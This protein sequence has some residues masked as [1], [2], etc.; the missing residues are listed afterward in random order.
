[1]FLRAPRFPGLIGAVTIKSSE[2]HRASQMPDHGS[3]FSHVL[4]AKVIRPQSERISFSPPGGLRGPS[5]LGAC[6][7]TRSSG[8][9]FE[10]G[11][12][13]DRR[14]EREGGRSGVGYEGGH[15]V[16]RETLKPVAVDSSTHMGGQDVAELVAL[17]SASKQPATHPLH[18]S[19]AAPP[20]FGLPWKGHEHMLT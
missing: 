20:I 18:G 5:P 16:N 11:G 4:Q 10:V 9:Q 3:T 7:G 12:L 2:W 6:K 1:M 19:I 8:L 15:P 13:Q 14:W 17:L